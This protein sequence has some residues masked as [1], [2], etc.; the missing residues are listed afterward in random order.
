MRVL[1]LGG[2]WFVGRVVV[3]EAAG[4]GHDVTVF[5]RGVTAA[6]LPAGVRRVV[7]DR[8]SAADVRS[9]ARSGPWDV[10]VDVSGNVPAVVGQ[11]ARVLADVAERSAFIS[12]ISAYREWPHAPVDE[13]SPL[14]DADPDHDPGTRRW[15]PDA[16]GPL[17][18]GCEIAW[19]EAVGPQR[20]L[21]LRPHVVLGRYEYV[22]RLPWWLKRMR[23]G[24]QVLAPA[25]DRAVQPVDVRDLA[26]FLLDRIEQGDGGSSTSRLGRR[27]P[28]TARC[29]TPACRSP[30]HPPNA[31]PS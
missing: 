17:K 20:L 31:R 11:S 2:S 13:D 25:P 26:Q 15:D 24:G 21:V 12:T 19:H 29:C 5:N 3:E 7:G 30:P 16:Y 28:L 27:R 6:R 23:R 9:L 8:E 22:G 18:V 14:W 4:R 10:V 1:V